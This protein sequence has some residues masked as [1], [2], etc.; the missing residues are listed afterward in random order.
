M[1]GVA[2]HAGLFSSADDVMKFAQAFLDAWHGR[3]EIFSQEWV[4]TFSERQRM[5]ENSDWA[6]GWDTPKRSKFD[7][8]PRIHDL[9][10]EGLTA[11]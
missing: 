3:N 8:R 4:K 5:P 9:I 6:L 7:L 2:G 11:D 1:G 10:I